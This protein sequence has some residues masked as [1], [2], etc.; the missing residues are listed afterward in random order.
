[1]R[2][3]EQHRRFFECFGYL[4]LPGVMK[5]DLAW[6]EDEFESVFLDKNLD[7]D[8]TARTMVLNFIA[9]RERLCEL[10][11]HPVIDRVL[12]CLLGPGATYIG[13]DGNYYTGDTQWHADGLHRSGIFMKIAFYLDPVGKSSGALR[14]IPGSHRPSALDWDAREA[15][16]SAERW[17]IEG[18]MVPAIVLDSQPGDMVVFNHNLMHSSWGGSSKRRMFT[19]NVCQRCSSPEEFAELK[20]YV[21]RRPSFWQGAANL[22]RLLSSPSRKPRLAQVLEMEPSL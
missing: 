5:D 1:M 3:T 19:M 4:V 2:L 21:S 15:A 20:E 8:G 11:E 18:G 17:G 9:S 22:E 10:L 7:H 14:V 13:S 6:I 12:E 16:G